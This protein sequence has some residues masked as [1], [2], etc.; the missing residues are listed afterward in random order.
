MWQR[1]ESSPY[2]EASW[3]L[4][5]LTNVFTDIQV[6]GYD[7]AADV[8]YLNK[9]YTHEGLAFVT[10]TLPL[11]GSCILEGFRV[12][13][14]TAP[15]SLFQCFGTPQWRA[16]PKFL[17]ALLKR[18]FHGQTGVL[19]AQPCVECVR[20][21]HQ[22]CSLLKKLEAEKTDE[23]TDEHYRMMLDFD[24]ALPKNLE[25]IEFHSK[26]VLLSA[27]KIINNVLHD[28][29]LVN[30]YPRHGKGAVSTRGL[31]NDRKQRLSTVFPLYTGVLNS[32]YS[33]YDYFHYNPSVLS[34]YHGMVKEEGNNIRNLTLYYDGKSP[35]CLPPRISTGAGVR[36]YRDIDSY[37]KHWAEARC[38]RTIC[39]TKTARKLRVISCEPVPNVAI[40][41]GQQLAM[42]K[43]IEKNKFSSGHVNFRSQEV[44][45]Q[46]AQASSI[47]NVH[48][49]LDMHNASDSVSTTLVNALFPPKLLKFLH[50]SRTPY[51]GVTWKATGYTSYRK[52]NK[53][54]PMGSAVCFPVE[55]MIFW[56]LASA[57]IYRSKKNSNVDESECTKL[58]YTYGDDLILPIEYA[59]EVVE[60]FATVGIKVNNEKSFITGPFRESCGCDAF[61]GIDIT[62]V[63]IKKCPP[64]KIDEGANANAWN[65]YAQ[66][67]EERGMKNTAEFCYK[68]LER[69]Y[70]ALP[71]RFSSSTYLG[72]V[73]E[74]ITQVAGLD[75]VEIWDPVLGGK[76]Q[77]ARWLKLHAQYRESGGFTDRWG[78]RVEVAPVM[79]DAWSE[80]DAFRGVRSRKIKKVVWAILNKPERPDDYLDTDALWRWFTSLKG[81]D[82]SSFTFTRDSDLCIKRRTIEILRF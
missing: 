19:L 72:R 16:L 45:R 17:S 15:K 60:M 14:F 75:P 44:N 57:V 54:A 3:P 79:E 58:V 47:S 50:A 48:A 76:R 51:T 29:D 1:V 43:H 56:A 10:N 13:I 52:L 34:L 74:D 20:A 18:V 55:S 80:I 33:W 37:V 46:L 65:D 12:G 21:L 26:Q 23:L 69:V 59:N 68:Q 35:K 67:F 61:L 78:R 7:S 24:S 40:Q 71:Y 8:A 70:G 32:V 25:N 5:L 64:E 6:K 9:R 63:K 41:L 82:Q 53:F 38:T 30:I 27:S 81:S 77:V 66:A 2:C 73:S 22:I 39:V 11:Y 28:L 31:K 36:V 49:T 4:Q 42:V 62:P